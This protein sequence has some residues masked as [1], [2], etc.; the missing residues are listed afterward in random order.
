MAR[1]IVHI[2]D[3]KCGSTAIQTALYSSREALSQTG[4]LFET[5]TPNS[6]HGVLPILLGL[7][8]RAFSE[9]HRL[10]AHETIEI[11]RDRSSNYDWI[12]L[13]A[14]NLIN[15]DPTLM[16]GLISMITDKNEGMNVLAYVREPSEMY[17]S[18]IQQVV[19]GSHFYTKPDAYLRRLDKKLKN[20]RSLV[21]SN[22]FTLR[23]FDR[24]V[25][26][27]G[28]VVADFECYLQ[29]K[30]G[31]HLHLKRHRSNVSMTSEQICVLQKYRAQVYPECSGKIMD[32]STVLT[33]FFEEINAYG[34]VG[35]RAMLTETARSV[36]SHGSLKTTK[37]LNLEFPGLGMPVTATGASLPEP[38]YPWAVSD[39]VSLVLDRV[40]EDIVG[41]FCRLLPDLN[42]GHAPE[43]ASLDDIF[44]GL[45]EAQDIDLEPARTIFGK[46][47]ERLSQC[48]PPA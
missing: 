1:F 15:I 38:P 14:E 25:L 47:L 5:L 43:G 10:L 11:L 39:D 8:S 22:H 29:E 26:T 20:W 13:S 23:L 32:R 21:G 24:D 12:I 31:K 44:A 46:Y 7:K 4:I 48:K 41:A 18:L 36:V 40:D 35:N 2:G 42:E 30:T 27:E 33:K 19:K 3:G 28:D 45:F 9:R 6:G 34:S 16:P 17:L 37:K